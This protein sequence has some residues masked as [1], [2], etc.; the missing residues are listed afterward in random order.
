MLA[1]L[2]AA[3]SDL[4]RPR[5][6]GLVIWPLIG[7]LVLWVL[8][9]VFFW[10]DMVDGLRALIAWAVS[11]HWFSDSVAR[12]LSE[13]IVA[14][15]LLAAIPPLTLATAL[16]ITSLVAMPVM[17]SDVAGRVYPQLERKHGGSNLGSLWN[18]TIATLI[19]LALW[20]V[21]LPLWLFGVP[22]LVLPVVLNGW[23][24]EKLFRYDALAE[25]ASRG[26][27]GSL[28]A[29]HRGALFGIGAISALVQ[30]LPFVNIL[31]PVFTGLSF[32]HY[33]LARLE[34]L[35]SENAP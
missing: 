24:N 26:E 11:Q 15:V 13:W 12:V 18:A 27:Y 31:S 32:I 20:V 28:V 6:L 2:S 3:F 23:L 1:A 35:R 22:A 34:A 9:A 25:H 19:Y 5:M 7:A 33:G 17:V 21:T 10:H 4:F 16:F 30:T 14:V 8:I 29:R